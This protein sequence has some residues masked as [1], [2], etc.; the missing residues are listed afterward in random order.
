VELLDTLLTALS[1]AQVQHAQNVE[2]LNYHRAN[3]AALSTETSVRDA[4]FAAGMSARTGPLFAADIDLAHWIKKV[5]D[6]RGAITCDVAKRVWACA[7]VARRVRCANVQTQLAL[8]RRIVDAVRTQRDIYGIDEAP[9]L[10]LLERMR[11]QTG[12]LLLL[13]ELVWPDSDDPFAEPTLSA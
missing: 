13:P 5:T 8:A 9:L 7:I 11:A 6:M 4:E 10:G 3:L 1:E 12:E 2:A